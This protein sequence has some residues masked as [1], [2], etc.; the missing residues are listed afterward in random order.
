MP[1]PLT[2]VFADLPDPRMETANT[3]HKLVDILV[4]ANRIMPGEDNNLGAEVDTFCNTSEVGKKLER[5]GHHRVGREMVL[6]GPHAVKTGIVG[7]ASNV[8]FFK[9]D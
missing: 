3:L 5:V 2:T 1:L 7:D 4:I 6:H 8:D 9:E